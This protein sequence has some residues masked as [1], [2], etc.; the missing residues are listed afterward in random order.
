MRSECWAGQ[1]KYLP[2]V[3]GNCLVERVRRNHGAGGGVARDESRINSAET[4][5]QGVAY[6]NCSATD[7]LWL[8]ATHPPSR[9][10]M[11][12]TRGSFRV[13]LRSSDLKVCDAVHDG[14]SRQ[15][16]LGA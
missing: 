4:P 15:A 2:R 9:G 1:V 8:R 7:I 10:L 6:G 11:F 14:G 16:G 5:R 12:E 13:S 3:F